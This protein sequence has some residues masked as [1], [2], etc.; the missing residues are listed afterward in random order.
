MQWQWSDIVFALVGV[1]CFVV[2]TRWT[3]RMERNGK[4]AI[5]AHGKEEEDWEKL[6]ETGQRTEADILAV[7]RPG[8][9]LV[10]WRNDSPD[11]AVV[12]LLI[13][14]TDTQGVAHEVLLRTFIDEDLIANFSG[15]RKLP[16]VYSSDTPP[17]VA[18]DRERTQVEVPYSLHP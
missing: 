2:V 8:N 12:E 7:G 17:V 11:M 1:I 16:I 14:F 5:V 18:I 4:I 13:A 6:R 15:G 10:T 9:R 3:V